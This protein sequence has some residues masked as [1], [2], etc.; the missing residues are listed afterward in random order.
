[1]PDTNE[2]L[3]AI[4]NDQLLHDF[5]YTVRGLKRQLY[6]HKPSAKAEE[7]EVIVHRCK[8]CNHCAT[9]DAEIPHYPK[10]ALFVLQTEWARLKTARPELFDF[11]DKFPKK[12]VTAEPT[13]VDA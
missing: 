3:A 6:T 2:A 4:Q 8:V 11:S 7:H 13:A 9:G 10:C 12:A 1:M 5:L